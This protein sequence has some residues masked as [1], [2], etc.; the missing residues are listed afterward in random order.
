MSRKFLSASHRGEMVFMV[1]AA[2]AA[3]LE[4]IIYLG[5]LAETRDDSLSKHLQSRIEVAEILQAGPIPTT[6]LRTPM[7]LG[8]G[9]AS[10][11]ILRYLVERLPAMTTPRW[12][13]SLNQPIAIRNVIAYLIGCLEHEETTGQ[14]YDIIFDAVGKRSLSEC[15]N[16]LIQRGIYLS[17]VANIPLLLQILWTS[18][19]G[20]KKTIF[21]MSPCTTK[22]LDFL[23]GVIESGRMKTEI[24]RI[25]NEIEEVKN[26]IAFLKERKGRIDYTQLIKE[27]TSSVGPVSPKKKRNV[28]IAGV[29]GLFTFT[30]LAFFFEYVQ[31]QRAQRQE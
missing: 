8:S 31:K 6:D 25:N 5:G 2:T 23:K 4:R 29:L 27:P 24:D 22:E 30:I 1:A 18:R 9:S 7:I 10:F 20:D 15:K 16:S 13:R 19:I 14:T 3:G 11:E 17:T 21:G 28:L 26:K 12:V